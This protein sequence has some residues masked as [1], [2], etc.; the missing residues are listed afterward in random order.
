MS[1]AINHYSLRLTPPNQ[2]AL[3]TALHIFRD[4][5]NS[6][7]NEAIHL[8]LTT[9]LLPWN[10]PALHRTRTAAQLRLRFNGNARKLSQ[11]GR[12]RQPKAR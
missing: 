9:L 4:N 3:D 12:G 2:T 5:T 11:P 7:L 8:G 6:T 1:Q 10:A